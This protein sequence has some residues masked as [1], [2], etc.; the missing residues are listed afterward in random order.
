MRLL[1]VNKLFK[2]LFF[3]LIFSDFATHRNFKKKKWGNSIIY[4]YGKIK[5]Y[6]LDI[7]GTVNWSEHLINSTL[8]K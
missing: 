2:P 3:K 8:N 5:L 1:D 6:I 4:V 7:Q